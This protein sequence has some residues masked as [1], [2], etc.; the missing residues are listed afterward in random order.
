MYLQTR[1]LPE[2][3]K[4]FSWLLLPG[5]RPRHKTYKKTPKHR[6]WGGGIVDLKHFTLIIQLQRFFHIFFTLRA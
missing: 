2:E 6:P 4:P 5:L 3:H 1:H